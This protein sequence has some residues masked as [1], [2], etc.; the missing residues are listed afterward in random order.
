MTIRA[1]D[2]TGSLEKA[3]DVLDAIGAQPGG[4]SHN[5]LAERLGMPRTTV[6]RLLAT[7]V[8]RRLARHDP[9]RRL[10]YLGMRCIELSRQA[11][12]MPDLVTAAAGELRDLRDL[13]GETSYVGA[14]EGTAVV[15][16]ERYDSPH[17]HRSNAELGH[18]KPVHATGQGKAILA[19]L[20]T[21]TRETLLAQLTLEQRTS[22]T[23]TDR[24]RLRAELR[25]IRA[26]GWSIDNEENVPG[27]RCVAAAIIDTH[28]AVRGAISVA[29]PEYRLPL[30]R[31]ELLGS[32]VAEAA[33]RIGARLQ[34]NNEVNSNGGEGLPTE[35]ADA[36]F[37]AHPYWDAFG[38]RLLWV[39]ALAP[40]LRVWQQGTDAPICRV[41]RPIRGLFV[42]VDGVCVVHD[43]GAVSIAQ[44]GEI[45]NLPGWK[46]VPLLAI[47]SSSDGLPWASLLAGNGCVIGQ[48]SRDGSF[49]RRWFLD[50]CVEYL[51]W[52]QASNVLCAAAPAS[53][54]IYILQL[55]TEK[56]L[57]LA[58]VAQGA[59]VISGLAVDAQGGVWCALRDGWS[60]VRFRPDGSFDRSI[61]MPVPYPS[62]IVVGGKYLDRLFVTSARQPVALD[63][64]KSAPLSGRLFEVSLGRTYDMP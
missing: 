32:E 46:D 30:S 53:G 62:G 38:E 23:I 26:R 35:A 3:L 4:I 6:Y 61:P 50:E 9:A 43:E 48:I 12:T 44:G 56:V 18:R 14:L 7:L 24:R 25:T 15:S 45:R 59:G 29:G 55:G 41:N 47:T 42:D 40:G 52:S 20:D 37:G 21:T 60:V 58:S 54:A 5:A 31:L 39:D 63:T 19:A 8:T 16:L 22:L 10:Y 11:L 49:R 57:R 28:G 36:L 2:G 27:V 1:G 34:S 13:T 51:S 64:L 33:R 17:S